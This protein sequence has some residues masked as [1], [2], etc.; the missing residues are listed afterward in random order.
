[1]KKL[2]VYINWL[3]AHGWTLDSRCDGVEHTVT[4]SKAGTTH[5]ARAIYYE[6]AVSKAHSAACYGAQP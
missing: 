5:E 1:M 2:D 6:H 3:V 4:V